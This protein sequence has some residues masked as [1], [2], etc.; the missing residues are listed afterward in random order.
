MDPAAATCAGDLAPAP[1]AG[2][3]DATEGAAEGAPGLAGQDWHMSAG[4]S[5][6]RY[7]AS[8]TSHWPGRTV[9]AVYVQ[10]CP[11]R[12]GYCF[13][14]SMQAEDPA[15][16]WRWD[17][18]VATLTHRRDDIDGVV[19]TGGE[20]TR[21][22]AVLPAMALM[23]ELGL[24]VGLHTGGPYPARLERALPLV[25]WVSLDI[26]ASPGSYGRI[27]GNVTSSEAAFRSLR[28]VQASGVPFEVT[29]TV[30]PTVHTRDEILDLA[31]HL[32]ARGVERVVLQEA[33]ATL[34]NPGYAERLAGRGI[35]SVLRRRDLKRFAVR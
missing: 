13:D 19:F 2:T 14:P 6:G 33:E 9:A 28:L 34:A 20:P 4:P 32:D 22:H 8:S 27:T 18:V 29:V 15:S 10:G 17:D 35:G 30:D 21:Q 1:A 7:L 23:R 26:K 3:Y 24:E 31:D 5:I 16:A 12:C 11:W 25:D